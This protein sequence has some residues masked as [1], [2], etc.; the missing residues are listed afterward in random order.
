MIR[1]IF[2]WNTCMAH[3]FA[4]TGVR[5]IA[6]YLV[7]TVNRLVNYIHMTFPQIFHRSPVV[8]SLCPHKMLLVEFHHQRLF[9]SKHCLETLNKYAVVDS[10]SC[11]CLINLLTEI[12]VPQLSTC[13][14]CWVVTPSSSP[15]TYSPPLSIVA[16]L[17]VVPVSVPWYC[18]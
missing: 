18:T 4:S 16:V 13:Y 15:T 1:K 8:C 3:F 10:I 6:I 7:D 11:L 14:R 17:W 9:Q 5:Y 12:T 2:Y